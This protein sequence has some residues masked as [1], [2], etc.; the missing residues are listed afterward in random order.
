MLWTI[1]NVSRRD[2]YPHIVIPGKTCVFFNIMK[3]P[4]ENGPVHPQRAGGVVGV[5]GAALGDRQYRRLTLARGAFRAR[6][7]GWS[8]PARVGRRAGAGVL[9]RV[10]A[11]ACQNIAAAFGF[12]QPVFG[13]E[14][15]AGGDI[16]Q[17]RYAQLHRR[18]LRQAQ[19]VR[20]KCGFDNARPAPEPIEVGSGRRS[21]EEPFEIGSRTEDIVAGAALDQRGAASNRPFSLQQRPRLPSPA[22]GAQTPQLHAG[23]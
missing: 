18:D 9:I 21:F 11:G 15:R 6:S 16:A 4:A 17:V 13:F 3:Y 23:W 20:I 12:D 10:P 14:Y 19:I 8:E 5:G 22:G 1:V 2:H 7:L